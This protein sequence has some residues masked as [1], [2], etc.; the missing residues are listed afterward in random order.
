MLLLFDIG[1]TNMRIGV[2]SDGSTIAKS[3]IIPTPQDFNQGILAF[4]QTADE[5]SGGEK[6][7]DVAG[8]A[9]IILDSDKTMAVRSTHLKGWINKP[10]KTELEKIFEAPTHIENDSHIAGLGEATS[11]AGK[12]ENIV[13]FINIGTGIGGIR[14]VNGKMDQGYVNFEP[15]HQIIV[16]DGEPCDCGGFGHFESYVGGSGIEKIYHQKGESIT[17]PAI[18]DKIS[19]YLAMGLNNTIVHWAPDI[20]VLGGSVVKSIPLDSTK[21]HL[22]T[23][24]KALPKIPNIVPAKLS[25]D[26]GLYGALELLK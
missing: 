19:R 8:G 5:L 23:L 4:K 24:L 14:V 22:S 11:G 21:K 18:W 16:A 7:T 12:G 6:I 2:S 26:G 10:L 9:A 25:G 20:V 17:D 1:G 3:K 13:A 15:G